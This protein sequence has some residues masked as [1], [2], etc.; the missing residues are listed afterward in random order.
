MAHE[1]WNQFQA[2]KQREEVLQDVMYDAVAE[3]ELKKD[4]VLMEVDNILAKPLDLPLA[5]G[6]KE[7]DIRN[8]KE[9]LL[10]LHGTMHVH[11]VVDPNSLSQT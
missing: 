7:S 6:S 10:M 3:G 2:T 4:G 5:M 11:G 9:Q 8:Q 1:G